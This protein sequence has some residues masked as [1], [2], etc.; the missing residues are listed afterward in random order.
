MVR[1]VTVGLERLDG[2]SSEEDAVSIPL[3]LLLLSL[4]HLSGVSR[5]VCIHSPKFR[6]S[7]NIT[8][9]IQILF[10]H[11]QQVLLELDAT[12]LEIR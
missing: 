7:N 5:A 4:T 6:V 1:A 2:L 12:Q 11:H 3:S 9:R 10:S 8:V